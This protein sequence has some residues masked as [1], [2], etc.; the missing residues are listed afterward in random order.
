MRRVDSQAVEILAWDSDF[1]GVVIGRALAGGA[2]AV[3]DAVAAARTEEVA[4][5]YIIVP[6]AESDAVGAAGRAG[7]RLT[8]LRLELEHSREAAVG[9]ALPTRHAEDIDMSRVVD[10]SVA[11]SRFSRF[12]Q[13]SRFSAER[14]AE[15][16]RV[17]ALNCL[18]DGQ[19]LLPA[20]GN[21]GMVA[22]TEVAGRANVELV[23]VDAGTRGAGFG[24]RLVA[25]AVASIAT[26][27]IRVATDA[28]NLQAV[29]LYEAAGFSAR[30]LDAIFHL[31]LDELT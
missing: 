30:S 5:L 21:E 7:A 10:L 28:R 24:R 15:M 27:P 13:D 11:L 25:A 8:A 14:V 3:V 12:A 26:R 22:V 29:R 23:Y 6:G 1:F 4:C 18:R 19:I 2:D 16:Y 31:W 20:D 9:E 17:W